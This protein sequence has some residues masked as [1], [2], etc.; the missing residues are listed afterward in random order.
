M[1]GK[2]SRRV[3]WLCFVTGSVTFLGFLGL[4]AGYILTNEPGFQYLAALAAGVSIAAYVGAAVLKES[5]RGHAR[6]FDVLP[7]RRQTGDSH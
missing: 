3:R 4:V 5:D 1:Q 2:W 7:Q 6:G